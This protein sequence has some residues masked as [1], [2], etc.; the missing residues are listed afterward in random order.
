MSQNTRARL[1]SKFSQLAEKSSQKLE[2]KA[3][4]EIFKKAHNPC[5]FNIHTHMTQRELSA[6]HRLGK[7]FSNSINALEIGSYLG[8]STC[9]LAA[10]LAES[11]GHLFCVDTWQNQ[12]MPEGEIDTFLEFQNNIAGFQ[13]NITMI[14]KYSQDLSY[15]DVN[16]SLHLV[17]LDGDHSYDAVKTDFAIV[18]PWIVEGGILA[19]HDCTYFESV[20]RTLGEIL[21]T[22]RWQLGGN[23]DSL[24]WLRKVGVNI[25]SFPNPMK[26]SDA[27]LAHG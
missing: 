15:S 10:A 13:Q 20:S 11:G 27:K 22:G 21:A 4:I 6:L 18:S 26:S 23:V 14:R 7:E 24:V 12:T 8:A 17:F 25:H 1:L 3:Y 2:R 5:A 19:M 9:Y 16:K